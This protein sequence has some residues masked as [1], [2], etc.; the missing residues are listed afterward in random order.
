ME[1]EV[2]LPGLTAAADI[3]PLTIFPA[4]T[5][6]PA[7]Q[8]DFAGA[9][10]TFDCATGCT[11]TSVKLAAGGCGVDDA[12]V[13][14]S[15]TFVS[16]SGQGQ[17]AT[18]VDYVHNSLIATIT[19]LPIVAD[20]TTTYS[21]SSAVVPKFQAAYTQATS[22]LKLTVPFADGTM[23]C[24]TGCTHTYVKLATT[25]GGII[26]VT[27]DVLNGYFIQKI[28]RASCRRV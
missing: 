25:A 15:V 16:G 4:A 22:T 23:D 17:T 10:G 19:Y 9:T 21:I 20:A 12:C 24:S 1:V 2:V 18:I 8:F 6:T 28:G 14:S 11:T 7:G 13:G 26:L 5:A 27:A 3:S